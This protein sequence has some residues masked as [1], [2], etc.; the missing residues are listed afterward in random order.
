MPPEP[1]K[2]SDAPGIPGATWQALAKHR[3]N[4]QI[5]LSENNAQ[6]HGALRKHLIDALHA[7]QN[8]KPKSI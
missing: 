4:G 5:Q 6:K 8:R 2:Y 3:G 7:S 1:L